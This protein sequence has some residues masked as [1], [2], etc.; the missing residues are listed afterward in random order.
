MRDLHAR[1]IAPLMAIAGIGT[2]LAQ[3]P[4]AAQ[5]ELGTECTLEEYATI[6]SDL[7]LE[8]QRITWLSRPLLVCPD[9]TRLRSDSA[10]VHEVTN[11]AE[12][13]GN[14]HYETPERLLE[15]DLADYY[16]SESRLFARGSVVFTDRDEG[17]VIRGDTLTHFAA[18][19]RRPD[20]QV[21][22]AGGR[23]SAELPPEEDGPPYLVTG[24]RLR[25]EGEEFFWADGDV[26]VLRDDLEAYSDSLAFDQERGQ[27]F[28]NGNARVIAETE[29]E[30]NRIELLMPGD[31]L[32]SVILRGRG[33]L[34]TDDLEVIGE[35]I[36]IAFRD[37]EIR[38]LV[39]KH[40]DVSIPTL[41]EDP[42][43]AEDPEAVDDPEAA[44]DPEAEAEEELPDRSRAI[45]PDFLFEA[46]SLH[47][48]SPGGV[49]QTVH[50]V[51]RARAESRGRGEPVAVVAPEEDP[52]ISDDASVEMVPELTDSDWIEGDEVLAFFEEADPDE[53][54]DDAAPLPDL[55]AQPPAQDEDVEP[56]ERYRLERLEARGNA[57]TLYRSPPEADEEDDPTADASDEPDMRR[58]SI[59]Y[60]VAREIVIHMIEGAVDRM[61]ALDEVI[62]VHLEPESRPAAQAGGTEPS[63][64]EEEE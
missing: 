19:P 55:V 23:P 9:G 17:T 38:Q 59:S 36:R 63:G 49:L 42:D 20:E 53:L 14:V 4:A 64:S 11:R 40:P 6:E 48:E 24:D 37:E 61:E 44:A 5:Q 13:I 46:D 8:G 51:G 35:E 33:R 18:S 21:S 29:M 39:A 22:V 12:L 16:E 30:A 50:G 3:T 10:V 52:D 41:E 7:P 26:E 57:R 25:F 62:G 54:A 32:E 28:L 15:A 47:V 1:R 34:T 27:L 60:V 56:S 2:M 58:W 31:V 43:P 45:S